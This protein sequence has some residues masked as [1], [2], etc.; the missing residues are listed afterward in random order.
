MT[1]QETIVLESRW[2]II[3]VGSRVFY[4]R[5]LRREDLTVNVGPVWILDSQVKKLRGKEIKTLKVL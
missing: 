2:R 5:L 1:M 3:S 4:N